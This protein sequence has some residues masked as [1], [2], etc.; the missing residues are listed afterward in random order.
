MKK[1][2]C[3]TRSRT[4]QPKNQNKKR[5]AGCG[6]QI[7]VHFFFMCLPSNCN[8]GYL[9]CHL[10]GFFPLR[11]VGAFKCSGGRPKKPNLFSQ[12]GGLIFSAAN[13]DSDFASESAMGCESWLP[14]PSQPP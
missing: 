5:K 2:M 8:D 11:G 3:K 13:L 4:K 14:K 7:P 6:V 1:R 10:D 12:D 9:P